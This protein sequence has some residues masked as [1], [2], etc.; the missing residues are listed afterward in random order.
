MVRFIVGSVGMGLSL[1]AYFIMFRQYRLV[2][3]VVWADDLCIPSLS[4]V[5]WTTFHSFFVRPA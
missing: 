1:V 3:M 2:S 4:T 5:F